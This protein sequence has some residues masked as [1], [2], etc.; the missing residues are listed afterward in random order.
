MIHHTKVVIGERI[1]WPVDLERAGGVAAVGVAQVARDATVLAL[2]FRDRVERSAGQTG[3]GRV[4]AAAGN[5]QQ[6]KACAVLLEVDANGAFFVETHG[7]FSLLS[8]HA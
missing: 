1:P 7:G 5:E 8:K 2:E 3:D 4:Q 6:R